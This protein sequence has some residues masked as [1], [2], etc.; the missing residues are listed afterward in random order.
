VSESTTPDLPVLMQLMFDEINAGDIDAILGFFAPD[1]VWDFN[2]WGI[3]TFDGVAEIRGFVED[4]LAN[5]DDYLLV[6]EEILDLGAGVVF[7]AYRETGRPYG[8]PGRV[9]QRRGGVALVVQGEVVRIAQY[10]D[11]EQDRA[12]A[13]RLAEERG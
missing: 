2:D 5:W 12:A 7:A 6:A 8:S 10:L 11:A 3:G 13:E 4:W 1:A 9:N